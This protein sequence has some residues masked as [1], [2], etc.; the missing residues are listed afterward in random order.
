MFMAMAYLKDDLDNSYKMVDLGMF[1]TYKGKV[2]SESIYPGKDAFE[3]LIFE[4]PLDKANAFTLTLKGRNVGESSDFVFTFPRSYMGEGARKQ[5]AKD[6]E[7]ADKQLEERNRKEVE[8]KRQMEDPVW[9]AAEKVR[10]DAEEAKRLAVKYAGFRMWHT[11][12]GKFNVDAKFVK[13]IGSKIVLVRK[14]GTKIEVAKEKLCEDDRDWIDSGK[15][16]AAK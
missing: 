5:A 12:D 2:N 11:A 4:V 10:V 1:N 6:K 13:A 7:A 8:R 15:W 9:I 16:K 3:I 14:D